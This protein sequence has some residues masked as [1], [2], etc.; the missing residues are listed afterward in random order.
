MLVLLS[1][2]PCGGLGPLAAPHCIFKHTMLL[3]CIDYGPVVAPH[4]TF[5]LVLLSCVG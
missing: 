5:E 1:L 3:S 4:C 2:L